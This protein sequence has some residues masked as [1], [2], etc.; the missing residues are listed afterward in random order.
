MTSKKIN[1]KGSYRTRLWMVW[2]WPNWITK[3]RNL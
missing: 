2:W 3:K 1:K